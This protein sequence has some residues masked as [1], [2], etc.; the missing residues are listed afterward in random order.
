MIRLTL[1]AV[2][3][4]SATAIASAA[5]LNPQPLPPSPNWAAAMRPGPDANTKITEPYARMVARDAFF[6]AWPMVNVMNRRAVNAK[7]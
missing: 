6:W 1:L 7:R 3:L 5:E 4:A 2:S